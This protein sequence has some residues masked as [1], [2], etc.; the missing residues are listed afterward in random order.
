M[1]ISLDPILSWSKAAH[2]FAT[3]D[4]CIQLP[5][6]TNLFEILNEE[7]SKNI[8]TGPFVV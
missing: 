8:D 5:E 6:R 3:N 2:K 4:S 7:P 1:N